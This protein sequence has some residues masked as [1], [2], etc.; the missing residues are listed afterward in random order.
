MDEKLKPLVHAC[1]ETLLRYKAL[2]VSATLMDGNILT[3]GEFEVMLSRGLGK[4]FP[5][6][7]KQALFADAKRIADLLATVM[8]RRTRE[9]KKGKRPRPSRQP[10]PPDPVKLKRGLGRL[11]EAKR[12]RAEAQWAAEGKRVRPSLKRL[13]PEDLPPG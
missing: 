7:E 10:A 3:S 13:R 5:P 12:L 1:C 6:A 9:A 2:S 11:G 4:Y 8:D